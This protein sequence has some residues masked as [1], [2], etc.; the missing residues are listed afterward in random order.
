MKQH[1]MI[2]LDSPIG[3]KDV[4]LDMTDL[5][6]FELFASFWNANYPA[7]LQFSLPLPWRAWIIQPAGSEAEFGGNLSTSGGVVPLQVRAKPKQKGQNDKESN[8][9]RRS[10]RRTNERFVRRHVPRGSFHRKTGG[11]TAVGPDDGGQ[12]QARL[13]GQELVQRQGRM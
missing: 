11:L 12:G 7:A 10:S 9:G 2:H 3:R 1:P 8:S 6:T 4:G 13:R 5:F